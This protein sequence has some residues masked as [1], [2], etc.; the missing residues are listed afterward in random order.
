MRKLRARI[1]GLTVL[2]LLLTLSSCVVNPVTGK[3]EFNIISEAMEIQM[4]QETDVSIRE[5]YGVYD[6]K[7][8]NAYVEAVGRKMVP[9]THRPNLPYHFAVLD[10]PVINAFAAPG[11]YIYITRGMLAIMTTRPPWPPSS[12]TSWATSTPVTPP[13]P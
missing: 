11:G 10:T 3:K 1:G 9:I 12:A 7:A 8:L 13:G 6:D 4:G 5:E 2:L